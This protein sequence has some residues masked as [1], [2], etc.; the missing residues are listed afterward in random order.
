[1]SQTSSR[2]AGKRIGGLAVI[3]LAAAMIGVCLHY[4]ALNG[5]CSSTGYLPTGPAR[6]CGGGEPL[7]ITGTFF[8]GPLLAAIGWGLTQIPGLLWPV[9]CAGIGA[10]MI[11][12]RAPG[13]TQLFGQVTGVIFFGLAVFSVITTFRH[14]AQK[15]HAPVAAPAPAAEPD[16][17]HPA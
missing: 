7:W 4:L 9:T 6:V 16:P 10:G 8:I 11:T 14:R 3:L 1:M 15:R 17:L 5:T 12:L 2:P 13:G